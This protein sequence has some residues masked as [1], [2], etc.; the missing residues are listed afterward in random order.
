MLELYYLFIWTGLTCLLWVFWR[1]ARKNSGGEWDFMSIVL[2]AVAGLWL[3]A[4]FWQCGGQ[5]FYYDAKVKRMCAKDGGIKVYETVTLPA[6][7]F[8]KRGFITFWDPT[9]KENT[10]GPEYIYVGGTTYLRK[11]NPNIRKHHTQIFRKSD[12]NL[13]G[14]V[15]YY[16]RDGRG[17]ASGSEFR[18]PAATN[19]ITLITKIFTDRKEHGDDNN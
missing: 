17:L 8:N 19:S 14:E 1:R 16:D 15:T 7:K 18:C 11:G 10:L 9:Q 5:N 13:L 4:S 12:M 2:T 6:E 3:V